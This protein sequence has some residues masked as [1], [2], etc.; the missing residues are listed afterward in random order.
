MTISPAKPLVI[1]GTSVF[2]ELLW[3]FFAQDSK[4][5]PVAFTMD[6]EFITAPTF[7]GLPVIPF[8]EIVERFRPQDYDMYVAI[9]YKNNNRLRKQKILEA[10]AKGYRLANYVASS[11]VVWPNS[12]IGHNMCIMEG[13]IV[14]PFVSVGS[15]TVLTGGVLIGNHAS[16]GEYCFIGSR[17]VCSGQSRIGEGCMIGAG[18]VI[19]NN[20]AVGDYAVIGGTC[21]LTRDALPHQLYTA[22]KAILRQCTS[23]GISF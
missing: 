3:Y 7:C 20:I 22:P 18:A 5:V 12:K 13:V 11:A 2:S 6:K 21:L 14:Q 8:E 4:H 19:A 15:G 17:A 1:F 23:D 10:L 9:G 16:V